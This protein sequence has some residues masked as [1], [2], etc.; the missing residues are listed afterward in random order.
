MAKRSSLPSGEAT[1]TIRLPGK[2]AGKQVV[3]IEA[4]EYARLKRQ[5]AEVEDALGKI[6]RG[7]AAYREGRTKILKSLSALDR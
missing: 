6:A 1:V 4:E 5:L 3:L 7:D 2:F